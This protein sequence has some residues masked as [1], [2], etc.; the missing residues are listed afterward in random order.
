MITY[1]LSEDLDRG[2]EAH[3]LIVN[4]DQSTL[5]QMITGPLDEI[6]VRT[7]IINQQR[8]VMSASDDARL[9]TTLE[10]EYIDTLLSSSADSGEIKL[11]DYYIAY[12]KSDMLNWYFIGM[13]DYDDI[14]FG[15]RHIYVIILIAVSFFVLLGLLAASISTKRIYMPM[16][17]LL[18]DL[19]QKVDTDHEENQAELSEYEYLN[20]TL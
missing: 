16:Y 4:I 17:T 11:K 9:L 3:A 14:L 12:R 18:K 8:M 1:I 13:A 7:F 20:S 19:R 5:Q 15:F 6:S 2:E 10:D